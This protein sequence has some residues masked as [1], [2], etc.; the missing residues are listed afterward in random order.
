MDFS[1][2][3]E[4]TELADALGRWLRKHYDLPARR[5]ALAGGDDTVRP[6]LGELGVTSLTVEPEYGGF[7]GSAADLYLVMREL[8]RGLVTSSFWSTAVVAKALAWGGSDDLKSRLLPKIALGELQMAL[9]FSERGSRHDLDQIQACLSHSGSETGSSIFRL[10]GAKQVVLYGAQADFY[11]VTV[12]LDGRVELL[13]VPADAPG[14]DQTHY[15]TIDGLDAVDLTFVG[16][17]VPQEFLLKSPTVGL[18][19]VERVAD[20]GASLLCAEAI[21]LM[22]LAKDTTLEHLKNRQQFGSPLSKFQALQHRMV[23]VMIQLELAR[24][25]AYLAA[26]HSSSDDADL[27]VRSVAAAKSLVGDAAR[28]VGQQCVQLHGAVGLTDEYAVSH[29]LKRLTMIDQTLG[30]TDHH[31]ARFTNLSVPG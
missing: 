22:E 27:R 5:L 21:G 26:A 29:V 30:D 9:A 2:P 16:T 11:L 10:D 1:F 6:I 3:Q 4:Q 18:A 31:L 13:L 23:D 24:S 19:L 8:G 15:R 25:M 17:P 28:Y 20:Y 12:L 7:G 14:I